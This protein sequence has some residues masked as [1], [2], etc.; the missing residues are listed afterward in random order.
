MASFAL[1][2][3]SSLGRLAILLG[4]AA[5]LHPRLTHSLPLGEARPPLPRAPAAHSSEETGLGRRT[6]LR[7]TFAAAGTVLLPGLLG[8][9]GGGGGG[10]SPWGAPEAAWAATS[11]ASSDDLDRAAAAKARAEAARAR[12]AESAAAL[13]A[14]QAAAQDSLLAS[15]VEGPRGLR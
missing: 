5:A 11:E 13:E 10:G 1:S 12:A 8:G 4:T 14:E 15:L 6:A 3:S 9:G 2:A 7:T